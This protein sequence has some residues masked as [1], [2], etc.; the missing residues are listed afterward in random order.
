MI[1]TILLRI[2][3][4]SREDFQKLYPLLPKETLDKRTVAIADDF[5]KYYDMMPSHKWIDL[6]T[7]LP[8][9][10][11]WHPSMKEEEFN[12]YLAIVRNIMAKEPDD[13]QRRMIYADISELHMMTR[14]ANLA[15]QHQE[16][17]LADPFTEITAVM[18][19]Y[20][21]ATNQK[22][23]TFIDTPIEELLQEEFDDTGV[24]WRLGAL[25]RST[26]KLRPGDFGIIA[27]RPDKGKTSFIASE[28]TYMAAQMP[29]GRPIIWLNNEGPG[30]RIIPRLYQ[31]ALNLS[32]EEMKQQ[33]REG[34]LVPAMR[35]AIGGE[36]NR[37]RVCDIH[38]W[39]NGQVE[40]LLADTNPGLIIYDMID[41]I[42]GFGDAART[43]LQLEHMY[44][45]ARER[46]VKYECIGL[47]TS[48]I[49]NEGDGLQFP[50]LPMLKDSKTGKQGACDFQ[51]MIGASNDPMLAGSRF[52]GM[53]KN[54]IRRPDGPGDPRAE[55]L[56]DGRRC[57]F[58]D[59]PEG[60]VNPVLEKETE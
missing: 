1:D 22:L 55:V 47:A 54:K 7:F 14:L 24:A 4:S 53:P 2:L 12:V 18:D 37:I 56:F 28:I 10:K 45:W 13:D 5:K 39:S 50:P 27:G 16:G 58:Y 38:G 29:K 51:I 26:R 20:R 48:Q 43:D 21:V 33:S 30:K 32:M 23:Q 57:R 52:I 35:K 19:E 49:S 8:R 31:A 40:M 3:Q 25:R 36:L 42:R 44:Q 15:I 34:K 41:S 59:P 17:D 46:S 60:A 6:E 11:A 9:F